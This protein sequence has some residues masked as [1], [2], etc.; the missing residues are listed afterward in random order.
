MNARVEKAVNILLVEDDNIDVENIRLAFKKAHII[1]PLWVASDGEQALDMLR[2]REYPPERRLML[3]DINL[4]KLGGIE[5]LREIRKDERLRGLIVVVLAASNEDRY[6]TE[7]HDLDA[8]SY[9]HLTLP[10]SDL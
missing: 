1:N 7:A 2:G 8:V 5:V 9:T 10:T 3:L 6:R 4:P